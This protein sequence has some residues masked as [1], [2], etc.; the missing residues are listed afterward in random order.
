MVSVLLRARSGRLLKDR[1]VFVLLTAAV[2]R[3]CLDD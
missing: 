3:D 1:T 2:C